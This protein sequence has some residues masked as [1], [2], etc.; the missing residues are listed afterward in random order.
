MPERIEG[1]VPECQLAEML[2]KVL[3]LS[4]NMNE[5]LKVALLASTISCEAAGG[6]LPERVKPKGSFPG[7]L[8]PHLTE[9]SQMLAEAAQKDPTNFKR[10]SDFVKR[11]AEAQEAAEFVFKGQM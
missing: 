5:V 8:N 9:A 11:E 1:H 2:M 4:P 3:D 6:R 10:A 7:F